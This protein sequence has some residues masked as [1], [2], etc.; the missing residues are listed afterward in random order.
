MFY[1]NMHYSHPISHSIYSEVSFPTG[2]GPPLDITYTQA[3]LIV[4]RLLAP[5]SYAGLPS[6]DSEEQVP[7]KYI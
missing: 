3:E 4:L 6:A 7:R 1:S 5:S 2:G